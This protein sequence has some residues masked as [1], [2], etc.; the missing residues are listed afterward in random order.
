MEDSLTSSTDEACCVGRAPRESESSW[1]SF[2]YCTWNET[3][4]PKKK[5]AKTQLPERRSRFFS[6]VNTNLFSTKLYAAIYL[7]V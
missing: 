7:C 4:R 2:E 3:K 1:F 6:F 5:G